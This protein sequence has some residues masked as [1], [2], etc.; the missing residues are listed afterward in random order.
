[1]IANTPSSG[2]ARQQLLNYRNQ[3]QGFANSNAEIPREALADCASGN[4][5]SN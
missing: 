3:L 2:E 4:A 5:T 1:M